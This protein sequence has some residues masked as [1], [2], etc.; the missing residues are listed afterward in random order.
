MAGIEVNGQDVVSARIGDDIVIRL[1][2]N[3]TTG[4]RWAI[5][6]NGTAVVSTGDEYVQPPDAQIGAGGQRV[7]TVTATAPGAADI[8]LRLARSWE[9]DPIEQRVVHVTVQDH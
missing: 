6:I 5:Q 3:A 9:P 8:V 4:Y 2:E 1:A 7:F